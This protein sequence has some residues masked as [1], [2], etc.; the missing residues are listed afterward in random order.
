MSEQPGQVDRANEENEHTWTEQIEIAGSELVD[1]TKELNVQGNVRR[2]I[3]H[4][5]DDEKLLEVPLTNGVLVGGSV[6]APRSGSGR[7]GSDG[8][9]ACPGQGRDH[10]DGVRRRRTGQR[11]GAMTHRSRVSTSSQVPRHTLD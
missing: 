1:R 9:A 11:P 7:L 6:H 10:S 2:L 8:G 5:S 3:I 4:T